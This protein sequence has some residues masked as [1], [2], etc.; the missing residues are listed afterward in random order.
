MK[1]SLLIS[2]LIGA[3]PLGMAAQD[4][5]L[6][7]VPKK[8]TTIAAESELTFKRGVPRDT[9]YSGSNRSVDDYNRRLS[10]YVPIDS[11]MSDT[12]DFS[13]EMGVYPDSLG[14]EDFELTKRLGR[15]DGYDY[16]QSSAYW[17]GY[18]AGRNAWGWYS[19]WYYN[20]YGWYDPWYYGYDPYYYYGWYDPWYP[21]YYSYY[22]WG[23]PYRWGWGYPYY[24]SDWAYYPTYYYSGGGSFSHNN[25]SG[26]I[27]H[28]DMNGRVYA[29]NGSGVSGGGGGGSRRI[30]A[31]GSY[32]GG[33]TRLGSSRTSSLREATVSGHTNYQRSSSGR[34]T[35]VSG[36]SSF[37]RGSFSSSNNSSY[38]SNSSSSYS[39]GSSYSSSSSYS[40]GGGGGSSS[41]SGGFSGGGGGRSG[42]GGGGHVGGRR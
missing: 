18:N 8:S 23:Y 37:N 5:D 3:L 16:S 10:T 14:F 34:S 12:I 28:G 30:N 32:G 21:G 15:F 26:T 20:R 41:R 36:H 39:S 33:T 42:G 9:Y 7:F 24:Y 13:A 40:G 25:H 2:L 22:G 27:R 31:T 11:V 17:A 1:K 19:P 4:D 29:R 35:N 6:Y 38:S